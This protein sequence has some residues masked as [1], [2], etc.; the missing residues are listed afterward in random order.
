MREPKPTFFVALIL[1]IGAFVL[2]GLKIITFEQGMSIITLGVGLA[3]GRYVDV[4]I[5]YLILRLCWRWNWYRQRFLGRFASWFTSLITSMA[6]DGEKLL[7]GINKEFEGLKKYDAGFFDNLKDSIRDL[8]PSFL[9]DKVEFFMEEEIVFVG[10]KYYMDDDDLGGLRNFYAYFG[11]TVDSSEEYVFVE[12]AD[13]WEGDGITPEHRKW[14]G[15]LGFAIGDKIA[16]TNKH[17]IPEVGMKVLTEKDGKVIGECIKTVKWRSP[18]IWDWI[19]YIFLGVP[20]PANKVDASKIKLSEGIVVGRYF[21]SFEKIVE[22]KTGM[23]TYKRSRTTGITE[24][25]VKLESATINV[26]M[27]DGRI[28]T[29]TD[30]FSFSNE[31]KPGDSGS[32]VKSA[33]GILGLTFAGHPSGGDGYGIKAKN[34]KKELGF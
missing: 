17:V 9:R 34:I 15:S 18:S 30:V 29:F 31:T 25:E 3:L 27:G 20:L 19:L 8:L 24:G 28:L 13:V 4:G 26:N 16:F 11:S 22:P 33:D 21:H 10:D 32:P 1:L 14:A 2:M 7:I 23:K 5:E 6:W 12:E